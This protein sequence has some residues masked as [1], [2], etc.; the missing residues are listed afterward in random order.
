MET[1]YNVEFDEKTVIVTL[2]DTLDITL[3]VTKN[4][5]A[6]DLTGMQIDM[7]IR[8][9]LG[10]T[11]E[12]LSSAGTSPK[13]TISTS[14]F[15]FKPSIFTAG[16]MFYSAVKLTNGSDINAIMKTTFVVEN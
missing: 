7:I 1:I 9:F 8:D 2:G 10:N 12:S 15:N 3:S 6:Q 5:V 4:A 11:I 13:I 16:G 14:T